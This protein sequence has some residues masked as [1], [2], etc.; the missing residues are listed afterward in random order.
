[1]IGCNLWPIGD[2]GSAVLPPLWGIRLTEFVSRIATA[3]QVQYWLARPTMTR[4]QLA[5]FT[6]AMLLAGGCGSA[7]DLP[8][9]RPESSAPSPPG[10]GDF[11]LGTFPSPLSVADAEAILLRTR[12]F[13]FGSMSPKRQVQAFNVLLDQPNARI[14]FESTAARAEIAGKLYAFCAFL[15]LKQEV[16]AALA[17]KL[18]LER[19]ELLVVDSDVA[20]FK[21]TSEV[22]ALIKSRRVWAQM[23]RAKDETAKYFAKTG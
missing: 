10:A 22:V 20:E 11:A 17:S 14:L 4:Y 9:P 19:T 5:G 12:T 7:T 21:A 8:V 15:V 23:R 16:P 13:A 2:L 3:L 6:F 1:M 18:E